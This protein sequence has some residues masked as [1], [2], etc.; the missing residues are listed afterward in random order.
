MGFDLSLFQAIYGLA[1]KSSFLDF[2]GIFLA[3]YLPYF[4][5]ILCLVWIFL[6]PDWHSRFYR[7]SLTSL[8]LIFSW[9]IVIRLIRFFYP[10]PRPF[11]VLSIQPLI[12]RVD[13]SAFPSGHATFFFA[14]ATAIFFIDRR[15][16]VWFF[17]AA[18]LVSVGRVF[19]GVHWPTDVLFGGALGVLC[20][21]IV[22]KVLPRPKSSVAE[23]KP[24]QT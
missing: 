14:M 4:L 21:Y 23:A 15:W 13:A 18:F 6:D 1:G 12:G 11:L 20:A 5:V 9:G 2:I 24:S 8:S 16:G 10:R 19:V 22:R 3:H 17:V 7:L